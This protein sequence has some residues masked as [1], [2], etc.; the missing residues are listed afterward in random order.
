MERILIVDDGRESRDFIAD[1]ILKPNGY[2]YL[3]AKDGREGLELA[4]K[5]KPDLILLDLQMPRMTGVEVLQALAQ[6]NLDIPVILMTFYGSEEIAVEVYRLG[7]KDYVKKPFSVE[8]MLMAI[9]RSLGDVRLRREKEALTERLIQ[10]NRQLQ[11]SLNEL[12]I[13]YS[14][15]KSVTSLLD[16]DQLLPRIVEAAIKIADAEEGALHLVED[17][18]LICRALR[19]RGAGRAT[20]AQTPVKDAFAMQ[21]VS[22]R[23]PLVYPPNSGERGASP[24]AAAPLILHETVIGVLEVTNQSSGS[25]AF[26]EHHCALLSALSDYAAI[27]IENSRLY[28]QLREN[29]EREKTQIVNTF[30]RFVSPGVV[31]RV[32]AQPETAR[33]G[34]ESREIT[35][36]F[37]DMR[38]YTTL[39]ERLSPQALLEVLNAYLSLA[40][41][42]ILSYGG[43]IDKYM[44]D[45]LMAIFNAPDSQPLPTHSAVNAAL[46]LQIAIQQMNAERGE[47]I[48]FGVGI[49]A[50]EAI[51]GYVGTES[52]VNYTAIGDVV[53][54]ARRL[55]E[56]ARA[57]QILV[58]DAVA[59]DLPPAVTA[60]SLG[61]LKIRGRVAPARA[62]EVAGTPPDA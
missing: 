27:A 62:H 9:E 29:T 25:A 48:L 21:V 16:L 1:Y 59:A 43:T 31:E 11:R 46:M 60:K 47:Q 44:G 24:A 30:G 35:V 56:A 14:I 49:G 32:V 42:V 20:A 12:N 26:S 5:H 7:V 34:G 52:A 54:V 39:A 50:G 36:L 6:Q 8:E 13:L 57:G 17:G 61:E 15:G 23:K 22:E 38:G 4:V 2:D 41:N 45:G 18:G 19:K 37:A 58:D 40:A 51:V 28:Q 55:T 3:T 10:S 53:N 33:P